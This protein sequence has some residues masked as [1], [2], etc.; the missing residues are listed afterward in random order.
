MFWCLVITQ[1]YWCW[2]AIKKLRVTHY[3]IPFNFSVQIP[4]IRVFDT[5]LKVLAAP[6]QQV[7]CSLVKS[8]LILLFFSHPSKHLC[9]FPNAQVITSITFTLLITSTIKV[10]S[11]FLY[12][13]PLGAGKNQHYHSKNKRFFKA[14]RW[15]NALSDKGIMSLCVETRKE[16]SII[17]VFSLFIH[18]FFYHSLFG[19]VMELAKRWNVVNKRQICPSEMFIAIFYR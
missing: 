3:I 14:C 11:T 10:A 15:W 18:F 8:S 16:H 4:W 1:V 9:T 6:C 13:M 7:F 19:S 5:S 17:I 12:K 2:P